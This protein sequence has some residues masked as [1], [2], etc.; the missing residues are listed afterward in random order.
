[1]HLQGSSSRDRRLR[2]ELKWSSSTSGQWVHG[3][4]SWVRSV[5]TIKALGAL[6]T[7]LEKLQVS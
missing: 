2:A 4:K 7:V 5:R 3:W 1:M 6:T